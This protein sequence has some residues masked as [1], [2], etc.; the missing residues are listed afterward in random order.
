MYAPRLVEKLTNEVV[1]LLSREGYISDDI[2][3]YHFDSCGWDECGDIPCLKP[4][5]CGQDY[6]C[7]HHIKEMVAK[8]LAEE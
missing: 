1:T 7:R 2:C 4:F 8:K 5:V 3:T 6:V